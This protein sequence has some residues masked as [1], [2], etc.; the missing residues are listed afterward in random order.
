MRPAARDTY[1]FG[2]IETIEPFSRSLGK[3]GPSKCLRCLLET[4]EALALVPCY[5]VGTCECEETVSA[6]YHVQVARAT[7]I[8]V[9][10]FDP[11]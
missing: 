3:E 4:H 10:N 1:L 7:F 9:L 11:L 5:D 6:D 8:S 2:E